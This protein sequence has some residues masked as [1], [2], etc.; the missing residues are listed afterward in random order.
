MN[1]TPTV[2]KSPNDITAEQAAKFAIEHPEMFK[3][4]KKASKQIPLKVTCAESEYKGNA[5]FVIKKHDDDKWPFQFGVQKA[6][7][8]LHP[9]TL[10]QLRKFVEKHPSK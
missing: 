9:G 5:V 3:S 1:V 4:A 10:E 7:L 8:L 2:V 6:K